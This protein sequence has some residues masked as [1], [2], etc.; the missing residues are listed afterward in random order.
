MSDIIKKEVFS[1]SICG[2]LSQEESVIQKCLTRHNNVNLKKNKIDYLN[3][4][5]KEYILEPLYILNEKHKNDSL[6]LED[7]VKDY[8]NIYNVFIDISKKIG[9]IFDIDKIC[10]VE[11]LCIKNNMLSFTFSYRNCLIK[12]ALEELDNYL[13]KDLKISSEKKRNLIYDIECY[14]DM[15]C[16]KNAAYSTA[17]YNN[18][19]DLLRKYKIFVNFVGHAN[20]ISGNVR[21]SM[22][23]DFLEKA[24]ED[25]NII[26]NIKLKFNKSYSKYLSDKDEYWKDRFPAV[27]ISDLEYLKLS[28]DVDETEA[29]INALLTKKESLK[30]DIENRKKQL[31]SMDEENHPKIDK[32]ITS[33]EGKLLKLLSKEH[34]DLEQYSF[35]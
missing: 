31:F 13:F 25:L 20:R 34:Q 3:K 17:L 7:R 26:N 15:L 29:L 22:P 23:L 10:V 18:N 32:N 12:N 2:K 1:C 30:I 24:K 5:M 16:L 27:M 4:R 11:S 28:S 33:E 14:N 19:Y 6:T 21:V 9:I 35:M 8:S